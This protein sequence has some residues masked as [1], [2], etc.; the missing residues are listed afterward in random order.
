MRQKCHYP[1][2][3][4]LGG[5]IINVL[6]LLWIKLI[7]RTGAVAI[8]HGNML[9]VNICYSDIFFGGKVNCQTNYPKT[10]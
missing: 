10:Q 1:A 2:Y 7:P 6:W 8:L 9:N 3:M 5:G 4:K